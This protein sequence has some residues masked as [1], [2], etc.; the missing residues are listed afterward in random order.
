MTLDAAVAWLEDQFHA[1]A[2][3]IDRYMKYQRSD[4]LTEADLDLL[5]QPPGVWLI[6][7]SVSAI[8]PE[9]DLLAQ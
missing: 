4:L 3:V 7:G 2:E 5:A 9:L 1:K 6:P 8:T